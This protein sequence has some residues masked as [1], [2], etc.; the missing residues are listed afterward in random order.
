MS[1]TKQALKYVR[2]TNR[3]ATLLHFSDDFAPV[4]G[5]LWHDLHREGKV[6]IDSEGYIYLTEAGEKALLELS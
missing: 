4:G 1:I 2:N 3:N 6:A 5:R